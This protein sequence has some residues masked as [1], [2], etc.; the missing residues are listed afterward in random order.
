MFIKKIAVRPHTPIVLNALSEKLFI[1]GHEDVPLTLSCLSVGGFPEQTVDWYR[2]DEVQTKLNNCTTGTK[3]DNISNTYNVT[4]TCVIRPVREHNNDTFVCKSSYNNA[5]V[6]IGVTEIVLQL[7]CKYI[8]VVS[9]LLLKHN[10]PI[11][12]IK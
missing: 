9:I 4:Q 3:H 2:L 12:I 8:H 10:S 6:L 7:I 11:K 1:H 5:P